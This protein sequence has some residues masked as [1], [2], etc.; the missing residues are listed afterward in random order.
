M[1]LGVTAGVGAG[2]GG[3]TP[4]SRSVYP[5]NRGGVAYLELHRS[6][7]KQLLQVCFALEGWSAGSEK[8]KQRIDEIT[9]CCWTAC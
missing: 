6:P 1:P 8:G 2:A 5:V 7:E 3:A 9:H 4:I